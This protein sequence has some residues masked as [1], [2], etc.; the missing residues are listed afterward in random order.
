MDKTK[1]GLILSILKLRK[2]KN[3]NQSRNSFRSDARFITR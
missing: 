2:K 1:K 3:A